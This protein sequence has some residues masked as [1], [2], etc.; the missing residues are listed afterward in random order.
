VVNRWVLSG[1]TGQRY[2]YDPHANTV[3]IAPFSAQDLS[4]GTGGLNIFDAPSVAADLTKV[5]QGTAG[6]T[7][8]LPQ[9]TLDG[10]TVDAIQMDGS[11]QEHLLQLTVY[12]DAQ[13][14]L[15]RGLDVTM[16]DYSLQLRV[17][18]YAAVAASAVPA[19]TVA[20]NVPATARVVASVAEPAVGP[21]GG[22]AGG[23]AA[24]DLHLPGPAAVL[25]GLCHTTAAALQA[26]MQPGRKS[27][28]AACQATDAGMTQA[29][30]VAAIAATLK[31]FFDAAVAAGTITPA[32]AAHQLAAIQA[33]G[34]AW[35]VKSP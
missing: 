33:K 15:V 22:S 1:A 21:Q 19:G 28:L 14:Y 23:R 18:T 3:A 11:T 12:F 10:V 27:P 32:D 17:R 16:P 5:R 8:L 2:V 34:P 35:V 4:A 30:L 26:A 31:P 25:A 6:R 20:L 9:Q 13:S 7:H 24:S 29:G